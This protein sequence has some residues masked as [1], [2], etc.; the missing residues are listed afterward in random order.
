M[1]DYDV[2]ARTRPV[3]TVATERR[4]STR[5]SAHGKV[6]DW[7]VQFIDLITVVLLRCHLFFPGDPS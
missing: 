4:A 5:L 3:S 1:Q 6:S 7:A 2:G